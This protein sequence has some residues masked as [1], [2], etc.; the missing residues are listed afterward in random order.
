VHEGLTVVTIIMPISWRTE[1][2]FINV[3]FCLKKDTCYCLYVFSDIRLT[4]MK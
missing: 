3:L 1:H 2:Y 4:L